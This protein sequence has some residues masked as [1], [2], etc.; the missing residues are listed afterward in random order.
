MRHLMG[1][2]HFEVYILASRARGTLYVGMTNDLRRRVWEHGGGVV[3]G[4][5]KECGVKMPA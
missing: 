4:F 1:P 3:E 5:T 2:W